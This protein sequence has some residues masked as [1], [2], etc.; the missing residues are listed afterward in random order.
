M[1]VRR[2]ALGVTVIVVEVDRMVVS[3]GINPLIE[4]RIAMQQ[5]ARCALL[6]LFGIR[7]RI[8]VEVVV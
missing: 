8:E 5:A 6:V 7:P 4:F 1:V 3:V 2:V